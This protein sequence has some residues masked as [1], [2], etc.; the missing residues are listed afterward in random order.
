MRL[1][2]LLCIS[3]ISVASEIPK[4]IQRSGDVSYLVLRYSTDIPG[5]PAP[6]NQLSGI[7]VWL[8]SKHPQTV[9]FR[10]TVQG[11]E[12]GRLVTD[13]RLVVATSEFSPELFLRLNNRGFEYVG[14]RIE[15]L[16]SEPPVVDTLELN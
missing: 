9:A 16:K 6:L 5:L 7:Q 11:R 4:D 2:L 13:T 8:K 14:L 1:I 15:E 10:V 12:M 3:F